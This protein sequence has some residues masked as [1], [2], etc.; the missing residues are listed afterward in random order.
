VAVRLPALLLSKVPLAVALT[1]SVS[2]NPLSLPTVMAAVV[3][4]S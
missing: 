2:T 1:V 3:L 4:P